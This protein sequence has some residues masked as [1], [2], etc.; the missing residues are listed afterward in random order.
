MPTQTNEITL[1]TP[2][3][4]LAIVQH[5]DIE[6]LRALGLTNVGRLVAHLPH[7]HEHE[8]AEDDIAELPA[9]RIVTARGVVQETKVQ[10]FGR[11]PRFE[12]SIADETGAIRCLWFNQAYLHRKIHPEMTLRVQGKAKRTEHGLQ[13][14]NP[15]W[16]A[17][18]ESEDPGR[19]AERIRP[20][21]P[22]TEGMH[23]RRLERIIGSVLDAALPLI[24]DHL[25]EEFRAARALPSLAEA[26]RMM[27]R[28]AS[29]EELR[30]A[31]RRLAY[32]ELL[33]LQTA[34][35]LR[36]RA[37]RG[38]GL[39]AALP[40]TEEIAAR[41]SARF[42]FEM[43]EWQ[44]KA[45]DE[46]A[47]DLASDVPACRLL[48]GDVG[49]GKT[50]VALSAMLLA[51][52]HGHQAALL[53][54]TELLAEQH[55]ASIRELLHDSRVR[56]ALSTGSA[57][58][59]ERAAVRERLAR[60][61]IDL[62][63]GT[64]ALLSERVR[65]RS[66]ALLVIDEQHRFGVAQR[67]ALAAREGEGTRT[68]HTVVMTATPIPRTL[69]MSVYGDLDLSVIEGL[70]PGRS[71]IRTHRVSVPMRDQV[72]DRLA[73]LVAEGEQAYVVVPAIDGG[74]TRASAP[75]DLRETLDRLK[76]RAPR[77]RV[78]AMH[79]RMTREERDA[80]MTRFRAG[81]VD[82]LVATTV[83]EVGVDV[84]NATLMI[85]EHAERFGL[86]QLHQL[87]GRVGRGSKASRC[88]LIAA[89]TTED[90]EARLR[91]IVESTDGFALAEKD[92]EIRGPGQLAGAAQAGASALRLA[93]LEK[94][95]DLLAMA[96]RDAGAWLESSPRLDKPDDILLKRRLLKTHG[97]TLS[98]AGMA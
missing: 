89:P 24:E 70:P 68:P 40:R 30:R 90:A 98:L 63:V 39:A 21:Y 27:H 69:A 4:R 52:A 20:I 11:R 53:A 64:H 54:P 38:A 34:V 57:A 82:V 28:P 71:P 5:R 50:A 3:D 60:G 97:T 81:E 33:M 1:R 44:R 41:I 61:E 83:I 48:Q 74:D 13:I 18:E 12:A 35:Q 58:G 17:I 43:T 59:P 16:E 79:G 19:R 31:R 72:Y 15:T 32:D 86:A 55:F 73:Q 8:A 14:T 65:F 88:V 22:T 51:A 29:E 36:R 9:G 94:D 78:A 37:L 95:Q 7:R 26:H 92:L 6:P 49:S 25:S 85:I 87:R 96:R 91:A 45:A 80:V 77:A 10:R 93:D 56:L 42:P 62:V 23:V 75:V 46:I 66:L 47:S 2:A 84:P 76:A 67:A